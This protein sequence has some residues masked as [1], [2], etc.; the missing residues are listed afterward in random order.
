AGPRPGARADDRGPP[1]PCRRVGTPRGHARAAAGRRRA[2]RGRGALRPA[3]PGDG[4]RG[5]AHRPVKR[6]RPSHPQGGRRR[7]TRAR[8]EGARGS[9]G[10]PGPRARSA[11]DGTGRASRPVRGGAGEGARVAAHAR[12]ARRPAGQA[13]VVRLRRVATTIAAPP[14]SST[15]AP[16][17]IGPVLPSAPVSARS[18]LP[19]FGVAA[20]SDGSEADGSGASVDGVAEGSSGVPDAGGVVSSAGFDGSGSD[21]DGGSSSFGGW[22]VQSRVPPFQAAISFSLMTGRSGPLGSG[23]CSRPSSASSLP[24]NFTA[25]R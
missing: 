6:P 17:A 4:R 20:G 23:P 25:P 16:I 14:A 2:R 12:G 11:G 5:R 7:D 10:S 15:A 18:P 22:D 8:R 21:G 13:R 9:R 19:P 1:A 3:L 24:S